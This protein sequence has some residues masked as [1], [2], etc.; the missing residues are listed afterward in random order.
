MREKTWNILN[1]LRM[2]TQV[3][4]DIFNT[5][6][7]INNKRWV[8]ERCTGMRK[9]LTRG[10]ECDQHWK[11]EINPP[12]M[13][14]RMKNDELEA[15]LVSSWESPDK[16]IDGKEWRDFPSIK[17]YLIKKSESSKKMG[18]V[19]RK[20]KA[21]WGQMKRPTLVKPRGDL[22]DVEMIGSTWRE[23]RRLRRNWDDKL[24]DQ[25]GLVFP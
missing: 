10:K 8:I 21:T 20:T 12:E 13:N 5:L 19:G 14:T 11:L 18:W 3:F 6:E 22:A 1:G 9:H 2:E 15:P 25:E 17:G 23:T 7:Q 4:W 16:N 24:N